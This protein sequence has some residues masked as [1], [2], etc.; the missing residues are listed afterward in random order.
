MQ[1]QKTKK[2]TFFPVRSFYG[3][4]KAIGHLGLCRRK[5][6]QKQNAEIELKQSA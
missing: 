4:V 6:V 3:K 5:A 1:K 2:N